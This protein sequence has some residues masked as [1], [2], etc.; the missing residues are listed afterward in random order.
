MKAALIYGLVA[1]YFLISIRLTASIH[2]CGGKVKSVSFVGFGEP[3][4]CCKGKTMK[5]GCCHD[6]TFSLKKNGEDQRVLIAATV[7]SHVIEIPQAYS[8]YVPKAP[9]FVPQEIVS[10]V[11]EPPPQVFPPV[12]IRNCVFRI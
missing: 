10:R 12:I 6:L 1:F 9:Y 4:T 3:E 2:Y 5:S 11:K 7:L 8:F